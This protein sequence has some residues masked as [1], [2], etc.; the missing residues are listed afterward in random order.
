MKPAIILSWPAKALSPN[1]RSRSHWP[2]TRALKMARQEAWANALMAKWNTLRPDG[3]LSLKVTFCAP[4]AR[5]RDLDNLIASCKPH[6]DGIADAIGVDDSRFDVD[7]SFGAA[8]RPG[9]VEVA[10]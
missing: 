1:F 10:L 4:D 2:R 3:R 6:M 9:R 8:A 5:K 7:Y